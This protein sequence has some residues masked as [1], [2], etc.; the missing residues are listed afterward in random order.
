MIRVGFI[1][2]GSMG[3]MVLQGFIKS[4]VLAPEEIIVSTRTKSKLIDIK[5]HWAGVTIADDNSEVARKAKYIFLC[6][7]PLEAKNILSEINGFLNSES[8]VISIAGT[9]SIKNIEALTHGKVVKLIPSLTSEVLEGI[10]LVCYNQLVSSD[11]AGY[12]ESLL[13]GLSKVKRIRENELD[14]AT[15]LTSCAPGFFAAIL[16]EFIKSAMRQNSS[17]PKK[18]AEDMVIRTFYGTAKVLVEKNMGFGEM[19]QRVA[20]KGGIT[21]EGVKVFRTDLPDTFDKVFEATLGKRKTVCRMIDEEFK[22]VD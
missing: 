17:I 10:S 4:G 11:E 8:I 9:V 1:G 6:V 2:Y 21:E 14:L 12:I 19:I 18:D 15:E 3:S 22:A 7:K 5:K 20:T 13:N 16:D